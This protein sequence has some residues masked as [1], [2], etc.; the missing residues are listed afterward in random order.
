MSEV[1]APY[2]MERSQQASQQLSPARQAAMEIHQRLTKLE[3]RIQSFCPPGMTPQMVLHSVMVALQGNPKLL[4]ASPDSVIMSALTITQW[5]LQIGQTAY[6]IPYKGVATPVADYKGYIELMMATKLVKHVNAKVIRDGDEFE[7]LEGD[8]PIIVHR[9]NWRNKNASIIGAYCS[10]PTT[11]GGVIQEVMNVEEI[12]R[13]RASSHQWKG[14]E[15]PEWYARKCPI[16]RAAKYAPK[17]ARLQGL[18][19]FEDD[20]GNP[21]EGALEELQRGDGALALGQG[22]ADGAPSYEQ[23]RAGAP[24]ASGYGDIGDMP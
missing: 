11:A 20:A 21:N 24:I 19:A 23:A 6:I 12:E 4:D 3:D 5:G 17:S 1:K 22:A 14:G 13:I 18:L 15:L 2:Q 16:R 10:I 8:N 9:P 7:Y